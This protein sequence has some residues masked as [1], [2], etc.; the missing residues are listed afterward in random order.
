M[1]GG[2]AITGKLGTG[3]TLI[4]VHRMF[5]AMQKGIPVATNIDLDLQ[6]MFGKR[7]KKTY[8]RVPD[9]PALIDLEAIGIGNETYDEDKDGLLV[10][11]ECGT[12]FNSR[13]WQDKSRKGV[14]D[15]LK[16]ARK[17]GWWM[18]A[19]I[20]DIQGLDSDARRSIMELTAFCKRLDRVSIP[21]ITFL[22]EGT[23]GVKCRF[24]RLH[25]AKVVYGET[26][27]CMRVDRWVYRGTDCFSYYDTKQI[28]SADYE[29]GTYSVLSPW[30][31]NRSTKP[32]VKNLRYFM[33]ITKI[34]W[35]RFKSP[36]ALATGLLLG[37]SLAVAN[38]FKQKYDQ[39]KPAEPTA[40][41]AETE[42]T[43]DNRSLKL[44]ELVESLYIAGSMQINGSR[45]YDL[46]VI[47]DDTGLTRL[48]QN[49][50]AS[51]GLIVKLKTPCHI[52]V[53]VGNA[54]VPVVCNL[55]F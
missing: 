49:D 27:S 20:Q 34:V 31:N 33:R 4:A 44:L 11:D 3:K 39:I 2:V 22:V 40:V 52:D 15:W 36:V 10:L 25:L 41:L 42:L 47:G 45:Q 9:N 5:V 6:A 37:C 55:K 28:F 12:W 53:A 50:L 17:K 48:N 38:G 14:N 51:M 18:H 35:K 21:I 19:I 24:P 7:S 1:P 29:A 54:V 32:A 8:L 26:E 46:A 16:H 23:F 43:Q 13:G 30:H